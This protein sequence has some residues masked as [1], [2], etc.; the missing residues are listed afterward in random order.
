MDRSK[1]SAGLPR[2]IRDLFDRRGFGALY[3]SA[4]LEVLHLLTRLGPNPKEDGWRK[5]ATAFLRTE[6]SHFTSRFS[7]SGRIVHPKKTSSK[8]SPAGSWIIR[9]PGTRA[10]P[11]HA[12]AR[13]SNRTGGTGGRSPLSVLHEILFLPQL[14][15]GTL[16][17]VQLPPELS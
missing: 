2:R 3:H 7:N 5:F 9:I 1:Q 13:T 15:C 8:K 10:S 17:A 4:T 16:T 6:D 14:H 11:G 12:T